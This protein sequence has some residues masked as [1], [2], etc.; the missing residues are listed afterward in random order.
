MTIAIDRAVT[1]DASNTTVIKPSSVPLFSIASPSGL[2]TLEGLRLLGSESSSDPTI[3]VAS[4]SSLRVARSVLDAA[5]IDIANGG[6]ELRDARAVAGSLSMTTVQCTNG[7]FSA[8][9][10]EFEHTAI[11]ATNCQLNVSRCRFDEIVGGSINAQGGAA[12]I[13]NNLVIQ[14]Y[15]LAD[16]MLVTNM[17]PGSRVR[18]NTFVNTSGVVS[19]G[20]ALYCDA[21][22]EVT[23]NIF[24]FASAH[25]LGGSAGTCRPT[26]SL[27]DTVA[28]TEQTM[29]Q[30][31][32]VADSATFFVDRTARD[33]HLS[34][35]SPARGA[36]APGSSVADDF[37]GKIRPAP[38][39]SR[40]DIG[41][42]EAP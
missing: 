36:A 14:A 27:F 38:A 33:F 2:V 4:G 37:D 25:P 5:T 21:T 22:V 19:D 15:E 32:I 13:E 41:C 30:G 26:Y 6:L 10:V 20:T 18:F 11:R 39:G 3:M 7:T 17:A 40:A 34:A 42:Y 35:T 9:A 31:N 23:S 29:G 8:R 16:A 12:T 24:A 28:L 1:I